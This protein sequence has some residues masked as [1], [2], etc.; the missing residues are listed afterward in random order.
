MSVHPTVFARQISSTWLR[1][2]F[3]GVLAFLVLVF[4]L[5]LLP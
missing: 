1:N 5:V 4:L 3:A 2:A